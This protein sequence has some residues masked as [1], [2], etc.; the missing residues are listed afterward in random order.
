MIWAPPL[1]AAFF[2][3][4]FPLHSRGHRRGQAERLADLGM[5]DFPAAGEQ[6]Q[7]ALKSAPLRRVRFEE[8]DK[9]KLHSGA[10]VLVD[11]IEERKGLIGI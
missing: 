11:A 5:D 2:I 6:R 4:G 3:E 9:V 7:Y 8:G 10:E 1:A